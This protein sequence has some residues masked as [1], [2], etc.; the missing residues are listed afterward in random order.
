MKVSEIMANIVEVVGWEESLTTVAQIMRDHDIGCV[1]VGSGDKLD[2]ILTD[3]DIVC[4]GLAIG[5]PLDCMTA[6]DVM[7]PDPV[8]CRPDDTLNQA[9]Y[10]MEEHEV[11]RLPVL[12]DD[13]RLAGIVS[14]GD[15][16]RHGRREL[17]GRLIKKLSVP[18][19]RELT[20]GPSRVKA[21]A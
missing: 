20:A 5:A 6:A 9:A 14:L 21:E 1:T 19:H 4:K 3:R 10:I 17:A 16:S 2:G 7:T 15:I 13:D 18:A 12:D 8:T 11:R